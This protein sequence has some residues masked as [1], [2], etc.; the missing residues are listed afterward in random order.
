MPTATRLATHADSYNSDSMA[1]LR[2][3]MRQT[4][5]ELPY[6]AFLQ[7][8]L[9]L[10]QTQGYSSV[11]PAGRSLWK[12]HNRAGGWDAEARVSD[13]PFGTLRCL[14]QAKQFGA[15]S[16]HQ[17]NVD[18]LRGTC[19][20]AGVQQGLLI[21]LSAFSQVAKQAAEAV[22]ALPVHLMDG[23]ALLT[24]LMDNRLGVVQDSD[25]QWELN[26]LYFQLLRD[27][28]GKPLKSND[29]QN[30]APTR[31]EDT[32]ARSRV[33]AFRRNGSLTVTVTVNA[34]NKGEVQALSTKS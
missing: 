33:V 24:L 10:L 22:T 25:G 34:P 28:F 1:L 4:L 31:H 26:A 17:R 30:I 8:V 32:P 2:Q 6:R 15:L 9:H 20:R 14:V 13:G 19:L 16:V 11:R 23:E 12:G 5:L 3:E 27:K 7:V 21:T 29:E 18:E